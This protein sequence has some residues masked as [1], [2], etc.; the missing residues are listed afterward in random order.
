ME[1]TNFIQH[2]NADVRG[3]SNDVDDI[4]T[5]RR[6]QWLSISIEHF[7]HLNDI[8]QLLH[9]NHINAM[10]L[11]NI[12]ISY[13]KLLMHHSIDTLISRYLLPIASGYPMFIYYLTKK[14]LMD[15]QMQTDQSNVW[16]SVVTM[17]N[18]DV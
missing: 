11:R 6:L 5:G 17:A 13:N 15:E 8:K 2:N 14:I 16:Q 12:I 1:Q 7:N 10:N 18:N 9:S 3:D 4:S